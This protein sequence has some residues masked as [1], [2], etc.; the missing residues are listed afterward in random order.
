M[1]AVEHTLQCV[2]AEVFAD[3]PNCLLQLAQFLLDV[4]DPQRTS[5][6]KEMFQYNAARL[7][8]VH[9]CLRILSDVGVGSWDPNRPEACTPS[10][11]TGVRE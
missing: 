9:Q 8:I 1:E 6:T 7:H 4:F 5:F 3:D 2:D 10:S 11:R